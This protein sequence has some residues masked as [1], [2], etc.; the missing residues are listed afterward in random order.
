MLPLTDIDG[1]PFLSINKWVRLSTITGFV[2][3]IVS[4]VAILLTYLIYVK[5]DSKKGRHKKLKIGCIGFTVVAVLINILLIFI[6]SDY[7]IKDLLF[8]VY[9]AYHDVFIIMRDLFIA[10]I[11]IE[12]V[13]A[14]IIYRKK[15]KKIKNS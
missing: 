9:L 1:I 14:I 8:G 4:T 7:H 3:L 11:P 13:A 6:C 5:D 12:I 10:L 15:S 2:A